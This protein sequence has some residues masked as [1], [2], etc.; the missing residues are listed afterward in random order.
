MTKIVFLPVCSNCGKILFDLINVEPKYKINPPTSYYSYEPPVE[1]SIYPGTCP[2]C[3]K[4]FSEVI[5][6]EKLPVDTT[7]MRF[8]ENK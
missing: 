7:E 1:Y 4:K 6:P 3:G 5:I 2:K 8:G